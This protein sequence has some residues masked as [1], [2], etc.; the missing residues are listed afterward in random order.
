MKDTATFEAV[1]A[2]GKNILPKQLERSKIR[3]MRPGP[4][5]EFDPGLHGAV[6]SAD[7]LTQAA[8]IAAA[9]DVFQRSA[10]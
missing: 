5:F 10:K 4:V 1:P 7:D 3:L 2:L 8:R 6:V 9:A